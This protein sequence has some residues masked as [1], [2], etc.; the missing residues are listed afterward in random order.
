MLSVMKAAVLRG[1]K[2]IEIEDRPVPEI[3]EREVRVAVRSV[4]ICGSDLHGFQGAIPDRRP[5]GL[6]MGHELAGVVAETGRSVT[7][8]KDGDRVAVDPQISCGRCGPCRNGW[9][10]ICE[11]VEILGSAMRGYREGANAEFV[12]VPGENVYGM[13]DALPFDE[14]AMAEPVGNAIHLVRRTGVKSGS[15]VVVIGTGAI[16]LVAL[17]AAKAAGAE[18]VTTVDISAFKRDLALQLGADEALD[19]MAGD[20][21]AQVRD[22]TDG[23]GVDIVLECCGIA[24]TYRMAIDLARKRG[25]V[26]VFGF[27]DEEIAFPMRSIIFSELTLIG[28]TGFFWPDDPALEMMA[29]RQ[30]DVRPLIT[31]TFRLEQAQEA[32]ESAESPG[33]IKVVINP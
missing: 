24:Q 23:A 4:A 10:N 19:P 25:V 22:D 9:R 3:G 32:Y 17:Q 16:G 12:A 5:V 26:G 31:H 1:E 2:R 28:S 33:A 29:E 14:G 13:P 20:V 27:L 11:N 7:H 15:R 21:V 8:V 18:K 30:V 6:T